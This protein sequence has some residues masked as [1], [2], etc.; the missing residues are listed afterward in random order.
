MWIVGIVMFLCGTVFGM[1][2]NIALNEMNKES[3]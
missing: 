1:C 2:I 3:E